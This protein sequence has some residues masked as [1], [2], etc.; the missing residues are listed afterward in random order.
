MTNQYEIK[1]SN[2]VR[3][4][5]KKASYDKKIIH[6]ILDSGLLAH[7]GFNQED[8][9]V[10]VPML[11]GRHKKEIYL[12]GARKARII[13]L[14]EDTN[15]IS[16]NVTLLDGVVLAR[17]TFNSSM[18]YRSVTVFGKP[19]LLENHKEKLS[20]MRVI[21]ENTAPGRWD[22][23]RDSHINEVKM[24]GV[25]KV[26]IEEASAKISDSDPDDNLEDYEISIWAGIL[27]ISMKTGD[28]RNDK[29][30]KGGIKPSKKISSLQNRKF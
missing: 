13:R 25:I 3:Q 1:K 18:H 7:V 29:K 30:L 5:K 22:E 2:K 21:S 28:L 24:T 8:G 4:L 26:T 17:S 16:L 6:R 9:P 20:A 19:E 14:L 12:H 10:V 15:R 11:Y 23:V 27:P